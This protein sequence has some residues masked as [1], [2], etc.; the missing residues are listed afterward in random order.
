MFFAGICSILPVV[1][2]R[3]LAALLAKL[4][5]FQALAGFLDGSNVLAYLGSEHSFTSYFGV[6]WCSPTR[7]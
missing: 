5:K 1:S 7:V 2:L 4:G 6:Q 3:C